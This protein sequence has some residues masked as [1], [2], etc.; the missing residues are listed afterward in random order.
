MGGNALGGPTLPLLLVE[1]S[2]DRLQGGL[3]C[4]PDDLLRGGVASLGAG[5]DWIGSATQVEEG[6]LVAVSSQKLGS[7]GPDFQCGVVL[8]NLE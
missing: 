8:E 5:S 2:A 3:G 4:Q 1:P 6:G 7:L